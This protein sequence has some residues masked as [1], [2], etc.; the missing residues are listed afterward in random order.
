[1]YIA[2]SNIQSELA[3]NK[4]SN[5][6]VKLNIYNNATKCTVSLTILNF[7]KF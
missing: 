2:V 4:C 1:M 7:S 6:I 3:H 5:K